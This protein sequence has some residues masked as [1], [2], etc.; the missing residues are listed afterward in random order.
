MKN[1]DD[2]LPLLNADKTQQINVNTKIEI[3]NLLNNNVDSGVPYIKGE[4][5]DQLYLKSDKTEQI[6]AYT[7]QVDD[8]LLLSKA[9][10][11]Q[12][13][14]AY[15]K[16]EADNQLN[17][18]AE[19]GVSYIKVYD[20]LLLLQ[21]DKT[22]LNDACIKDEADNMLSNNTN[23]QTTYTKTETD[24][25]ISNNDVSD[26]GFSSYYT[27]I[28]TDELFDEKAATAD[29]SNF[30]TQRIAQTIKTNKNFQNSCRFISTIEK[31]ANITG[32]SFIKAKAEDTV[33]LLG[34]DGT[35]H[36]SEFTINIYNS[37]YVK[38][39][40]QMKNNQHLAQQKVN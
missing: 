21:A 18:Q 33:V 8:T 39:H 12:L 20:A 11:T 10:K 16:A 32:Q 26:V 34:I 31:M 22:Q 4:D 30:V 2:T 23:Q 17:I 25:K 1:K 27:K 5:D 7:R 29:L 37:N 6:D 24:Q 19:S 9:D 38:I 28:K 35:K 14:D 15:S 13:I 3:N 36:I 40:S